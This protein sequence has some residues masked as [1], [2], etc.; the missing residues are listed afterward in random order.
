[1]TN[2]PNSQP[3]P[4]Q[5]STSETMPGT[6]Y[7]GTDYRVVVNTAGVHVYRRGNHRP[8]TAYFD[9]T[10]GFTAMLEDGRMTPDEVGRCV[11][12]QPSNRK[13]PSYPDGA[14]T[15]GD[16]PWRKLVGMQKI[17]WYHAD[18][19]KNEQAQQADAGEQLSIPPSP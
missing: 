2:N 11:E 9:T 18:K 7:N 3:T 17:A 15:A 14:H 4:N 12:T 8:K 10:E 1:M 5:P 13:P 6:I 19:L 16:E